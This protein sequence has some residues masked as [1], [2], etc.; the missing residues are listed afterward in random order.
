MKFLV[1]IV[2]ILP[3]LAIAYWILQQ[4]KYE[5]EPWRLTIGSF[6]CGML[7]TAPAVAIQLML[8][9][10]ADPDASE[11]LLQSLISCIFVVALTEELSKF[12]FLRLYA[13]TSD[14]FNEPMDGIV[15][16]V[17]ISMGFATLENIFY[18]LQGLP[19]ALARAVTAVPAHAAFGVVMGAFVG[20]AKFLPNRKGQMITLGLVLATLFHG[21]YDFFLLQKAYQWLA[22]LAIVTLALGLIFSKYL[23][24]EWQEI[25][26]FKDKEKQV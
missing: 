5:K 20:I 4:D 23:I 21:L 10:E 15:Y 8:R 7:S 17:L 1:L 24:K 6:V 19:V 14:E 25:S 11:S 9:S 22:V 3:G 12:T 2:A 16:S 26:P 18:S 13:Y